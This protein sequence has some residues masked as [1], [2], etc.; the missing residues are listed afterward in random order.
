[1]SDRG[2]IDIAFGY[3][4]GYK[5]FQTTG[6]NSAVSDSAWTVLG[7]SLAAAKTSGFGVN[8]IALADVADT[9]SVTR[10]DVA[11]TGKVV[12][13]Y[14]DSEYRERVARFSL[15]ASPATIDEFTG[16][17]ITAR[18][19]NQARYISGGNLGTIDL[20]V[21]TGLVNRIGPGDGLARVCIFTLPLGQPTLLVGWVLGTQATKPVQ[22]RLMVR[23]PGKQPLVLNVFPAR[24][25]LESASLPFPRSIKDVD[26]AATPPT[27][28]THGLDIWVEAMRPAASGTGEAATSLQFISQL[29]G[30]DPTAPGYG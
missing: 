4:A 9:L 10:T 13:S 26:F 11:D 25:T 16:G 3:A 19:V 22:V 23:S 18:R 2:S 6:L 8:D 20:L 24:E 15:A 29:T 5:Q 28:I 27:P 17:T 7:P 12:V 30:L 1:M 14:L 21:G